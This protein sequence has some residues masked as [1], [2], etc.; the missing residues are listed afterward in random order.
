MPLSAYQA[1]K[2]VSEQRQ[3]QRQD[4]SAA[5]LQRDIYLTGDRLWPNHL[6]IRVAVG[7]NPFGHPLQMGKEE[8]DTVRLLREGLEHKGLGVLG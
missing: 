2:S 5:V 4:T 7:P 8:L 3:T 1:H 6:P